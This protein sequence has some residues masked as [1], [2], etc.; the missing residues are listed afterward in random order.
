[1]NAAR[2]ACVHRA[3]A[4][5]EVRPGVAGGRVR[6][7]RLARVPLCVPFWGGATYA[8]MIRCLVSGRVRVG[9]DGARLAAR[10]AAL[11][12]AAA[13][14]PCASGRAAIEAGL[15]LLGVGP[16][17]EV[18]LPSFCC[19]SIVPPVLAVGAM[20]VLAD[21]GP[22]LNLTP[23]AVE[24]AITARTRAVVVAHLFGNP[25][26]TATVGEVCRSRGIAV[27]DDAA[28]ALGAT[29]GGRMAGALGDVG[30]LS[31]GRG[32]VCFGTGGGA[33]VVSRRDLL[34]GVRRL[35]LAS[36]PA[37]GA[38]NA[39]AVL[40]WRR[41]R[42]WTVPLRRAL[43]WVVP[44]PRVADM[45]GP[46]AIR[47]I[48]A[49]VALTL[50]DTLP[51]NLSARRARVDRYRDLLAREPGIRLLPHASG[52]ACLT[53]VVHLRGD[54]ARPARAVLRELRAAGY[55][56]SGSYT[57]LDELPG[58]ARSARRRPGG[59]ATAWRELIELPCEP[60]VT[61][62]AIDEI[63]ATVAGGRA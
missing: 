29:R 23:E 22:D 52:S 42:R 46:G 13:V 56:V 44:E 2:T 50:L 9:P 14:V 10:L 32:K 6:P 63:A 45:R 17:A 55:E 53:Q 18:I 58:L 30:V 40:V 16:G 61:E 15:R 34:D 57:P 41:W 20:P 21:V 59:P 51:T 24:A 43:A 38:A 12:D 31:F 48:D 54:G 11:L 7:R 5:A 8:A 25:A 39:L 35:R 28:Q 62:G 26:D 37:G 3:P 19:R 33:L 4:A 47:N 36:P 49:A 27:L 1:M 60:G